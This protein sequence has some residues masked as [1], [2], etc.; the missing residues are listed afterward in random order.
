VFFP[1]RIYQVRSLDKDIL[2]L[3]GQSRLSVFYLL[4]ADLVTDGICIPG[5]WSDLVG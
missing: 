2:I 3:R 1:I 4:P 5:L